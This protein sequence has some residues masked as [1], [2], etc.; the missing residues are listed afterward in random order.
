MFQIKNEED[1]AYWRVFI[2]AFAAFIF[3]TTEFIPVALLSDIGATFAMPVADTGLMMT[4]YAWT[5]SL[6]SLPFMLLTAKWERRSLLLALFGVFVVG[7][8]LSVLAWRFELLLLARIVVALAHS[9]FWAITAALVMRVAP[10]GKG[11]LALSWLSV[12]S[13]LAMVLGLPLGRILGQL[14]GWRTTFAII[15]VIACGVMFLLWKILPKLPSQN[16]G[17]L[18]SLPLLAQRP[19][20]LS[21]YALTLIGVTAHFTA[22][23]YIEPFVLQISVMNANWATAVL[24]MFGVAGMVAS[25]LFG[26]FHQR[27][28]TAFLLT[29]L[30]CLMMSLMLLLP[31]SGSVVAMFALIFVWGLAMGCLALSLIMRVLHYAS[32]ATD[33]ASA[34]YSGIFNVGIGG[35]ALLGG[36]VMKQ[37]GLPNIGW[38]GA[39]LAMLGL[40]IFVCATRKYGANL[41]QS[42]QKNIVAH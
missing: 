38:V 39:A 2:L 24:L 16:S 17:S 13:S 29:T 15:G 21:I 19:M 12:G 30:L 36:V 35:G 20:L 26:R 33:V 6:M 32:D 10:K 27:F 11:A 14:L 3:N 22:Y 34:I 7:H 25:W 23:S 37:W 40:L 41:P 8:V 18:K 5:V 28:S 1:A 9:V 42:E 31:L 4:V